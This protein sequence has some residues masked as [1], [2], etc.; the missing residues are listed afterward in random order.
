MYIG[1]LRVELYMPQCHNLK[2]KRQVIRSVIDRVR[3]RFNVGISEIDKNDLW[4]VCSLGITCVS[5]SEYNV[6]EILTDVDRCIRAAGKAEV[7][8]SKVTIFTP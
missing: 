2:E 5:N 3:N 7:I 4:Q 8:E 6:R 1:A